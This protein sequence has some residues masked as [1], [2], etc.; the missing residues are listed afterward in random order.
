MKRVMKKWIRLFQSPRAVMEA[1][2]NGTLFQEIPETILEE[3]ELRWPS[4]GEVEPF[5]YEKWQARFPKTTK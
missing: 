3:A 5:D 2:C 4:A 1:A